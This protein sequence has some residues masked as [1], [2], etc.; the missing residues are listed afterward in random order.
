MIDKVYSIEFINFRVLKK[1]KSGIDVI[2]KLSKVP[3]TNSRQLTPRTIR[4]FQATINNYYQ[5]NG[6]SFLWRTHITPYRITVSEIMLQQT[7]TERVVKKF[8]EFIKLFPNFV[9]LARA[10]TR[11]V[12]IAWQGLGYNRRAL[13]LHRLAQIVIDEYKGR[14]PQN[15]DILKTLPGIG[16]NTAGSI[17]AFAFNQPTVFLETNIRSVFIHY[18][19]P[20]SNKV[21]DEEIIPL[22]EQTLDIH[23]PRTWYY[24]LMDYGVYLKK[25]YSNPSRRSSHHSKQSR[26]KGSNRELRGMIIHFL[27]Q[28]SYSLL[29]LTKMIDHDK[30]QI[31]T[32]LNHLE[33]EGFITHKRGIYSLP[34]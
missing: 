29:Q 30:V 25:T 3:T 26:F 17:V 7:Q 18:F 5:K 32:A 28:S 24:G 15:Q 4:T 12:L 33:Q 2:K 21:T 11:D 19:F 1:I 8:S 20:N 31:Q 27:A 23:S 14:L 22:I 34:A 13:A 10:S 6:R 16:S 9:S